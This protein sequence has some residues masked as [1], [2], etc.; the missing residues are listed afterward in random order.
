M[1][2]KPDD[3]LIR[4][5]EAV[6]RRIEY[7]LDNHWGGNQRRMARDLEMSQ[8]LISKVINGHQAAGREFLESLGRQPG[9]VRDWVLYG[10]GQPFV[11][12]TKGTLPIAIGILPGWPERHPEKMTGQR[13]PVADALDKPS[14]Y[15]LRVDTG[16]PLLGV[17]DLALLVGDLLMFDADSTL[18]I[19]NLESC[20]GRLFGVRLEMEG[21]ESFQIG[22]MAKDR[23]EIILD[24][25]DSIARLVKPI[26]FVAAPIPDPRRRAK[27]YIMSEPEDAERSPEKGTPVPASSP[28]TVASATQPQPIKRP[29]QPPNMTFRVEDLVAM[30]VYTARP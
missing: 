15:W 4:S 9:I 5:R 1:A 27:R 21:R 11:P 29:S 7:L 24:L 22:R 8:A 20:V 12:P 18:W 16:S 2:R 6:R 25:F 30:R 13:H 23:G 19:G 14:R 26:V 17:P 10:Q 28:E 3:E